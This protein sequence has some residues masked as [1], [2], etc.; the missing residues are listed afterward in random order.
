MIMM[1]M[2]LPITGT[3]YVVYIHRQV[4]SRA[5]LLQARFPTYPDDRLPAGMVNFHDP[6]VMAQDA[7]AYTSVDVLQLR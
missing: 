6:A 2:P 4:L 5:S 3:I 7:R 1:I